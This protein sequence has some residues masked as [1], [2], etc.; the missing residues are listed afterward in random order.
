[1][2][3]IY[4]EESSLFNRSKIGVFPK[5]KIVSSRNRE[6]NV[7]RIYASEIS[8]VEYIERLNVIFLSCKPLYAAQFVSSRVREIQQWIRRATETEP[9]V[10]RRACIVTYRVRLGF[11]RGHIGQVLNHFLRVLGL[12]GAGFAGAQ[13]RLVL[14]ICNK[15]QCDCI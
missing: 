4:Y 10:N 14:A 3:I 5:M 12:A 7:L 11:R 15:Q 6:R 8:L 9:S 2:S 1:M 13:N